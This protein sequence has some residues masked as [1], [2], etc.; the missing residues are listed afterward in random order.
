[1]LSKRQADKTVCLFFDSVHLVVHIP[2]CFNQ[3]YKIV[4]VLSVSVIDKILYAICI[5][6][7]IAYKVVRVI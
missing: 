5:S 3:R 7:E 2:Q 6:A 1:M 4:V